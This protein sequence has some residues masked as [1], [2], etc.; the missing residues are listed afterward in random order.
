MIG[1][2]NPRIDVTNTRGGFFDANLC[3][4]LKRAA[5]VSLFGLKRSCGSVSHGGKTSTL[6]APIYILISSMSSSALRDDA[7]T[8]RTGRSLAAIAVKSPCVAD[9]ETRASG[10]SLAGSSICEKA[11]NSDIKSFPPLSFT[12]WNPALERTDTPAFERMGG[13]APH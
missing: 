8:R 11:C 7:V 3:K 1:W 10:E 13:G 6:P 9:I 12:P 2:I 5:T 4:A